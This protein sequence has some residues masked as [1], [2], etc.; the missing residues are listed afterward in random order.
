MQYQIRVESKVEKELLK[1]NNQDQE[2]IFV[3]LKKLQV[4]PYVG[5]KL[6]GNFRG[7]FSLRVWPFRIIYIIFKKELLIVIIRIGHRRDVY[8]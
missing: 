6:K 7:A 5:K 1:L 2:R 8:R 3:V 4:N